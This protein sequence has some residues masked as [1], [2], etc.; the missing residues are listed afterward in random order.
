ME[1]R[2]SVRQHTRRRPKRD[3]EDGTGVEIKSD[4]T[5]ETDKVVKLGPKPWGQPKDKL[6]RGA[7]IIGGGDKRSPDK[8][9]EG[10]TIRSRHESQ[11]P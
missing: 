1:E 9:R 11:R 2:V 8:P 6:R 7:T 5:K 10:V 3:P 4:T